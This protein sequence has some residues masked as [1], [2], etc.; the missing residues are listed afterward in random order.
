MKLFGFEFGGSERKAV[1]REDI[2]GALAGAPGSSKSG[3]RV[4]WQTAL[5]V[6]TALAWVVSTCRGLPKG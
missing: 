3:A 4:S 6:S 1:T 5:Q 2:L